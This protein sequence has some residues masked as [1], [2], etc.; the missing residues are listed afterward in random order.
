MTQI[1]T[2]FS[3]VYSVLP[4]AIVKKDF[5]LTGHLSVSEIHFW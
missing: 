5:T 4:V 1:Y 3:R 2:D